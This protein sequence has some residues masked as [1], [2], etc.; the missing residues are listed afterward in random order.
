MS[1]HSIRYYLDVTIV[2][3]EKFFKIR[4]RSSVLG[5]LWSIMNPLAYMVVLTVVFSFL[6]GTKTTAFAAWLLVGLLVWRYFSVGTAQGLFSLVGNRSLVESV[7]I[8]RYIIVISNNLANLLGAALEFLVLTPMLLLLGVHLTGYAL[9]LPMILILEF[10]L[11]FAASLWLSS[12]NVRYR[13]FHELWGIA[14]QLGFFLSPIFYEIG[15]VPERYRFIYS[16]NPVACLIESARSILI[17]HHFPSLFDS[18]VIISSIGVLL[19]VGLLVFRRLEPR[20]A[21]EL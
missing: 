4:Y 2:L 3:A 21:E 16:L 15:A 13:D 20:F 5:F 7:Y 11:V 9:L 10:F 12:L 8:P 18:A 17:H 6:R 19:A 14:L 1:N